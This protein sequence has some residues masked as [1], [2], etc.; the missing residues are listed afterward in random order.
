MIVSREPGNHPRLDPDATGGRSR[1]RSTRFRLVAPNTSRLIARRNE[2][3]CSTGSDAIG[4]G[5]ALDNEGTVN[6]EEEADRD[7][8]EKAASVEGNPI[9]DAKGEETHA[10]LEDFSQRASQPLQYTDTTQPAEAD[11]PVS[12]VNVEVPSVHELAP[13]QQ[14]VV[15]PVDA[16]LTSTI[17]EAAPTLLTEEAVQDMD[18]SGSP[19]DAV[20]LISSIPHIE[21]LK[22]GDD[23]D[24]PT[25]RVNLPAVPLVDAE[26]TQ[27]PDNS[28]HIIV[29]LSEEK[30]EHDDQAESVSL[31]E[32]LEAQHLPPAIEHALEVGSTPSV[33]ALLDAVQSAES[34]NEDGVDAKPTPPSI[35][36]ALAETFA[37][38]DDL[39]TAIETAFE[40][41][42]APNPEAL[43]NAVQA[44]LSATV[45]ASGAPSP[46]EEK[47][48]VS[49]GLLDQAA[50]AADLRPKE[51]LES[52]T[53]DRSP[54]TAYRV[55]V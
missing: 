9:E 38:A 34:A 49:V 16:S 20:N 10:E 18:Q 25:D 12:D 2:I 36:V 52:G 51:P 50:A 41:G 11:A 45:F 53:K 24:T 19:A 8:A 48:E 3:N 47:K 6:A 35:D 54:G 30:P 39:P 42:L 17:V 40:T 28:E 23:D 32:T 1:V 46:S 14:P 44:T 15:D 22:T 55:I 7:I 4:G 37:E 5:A 26:F 13:E 33:E 21:P 29:P 43:L 27:P 31:S